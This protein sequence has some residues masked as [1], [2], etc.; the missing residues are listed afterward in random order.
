LSTILRTENLGRVLDNFESDK[1]VSFFLVFSKI[2]LTL[3]DFVF[4][5]ITDLISNLPIGS[6]FL[7]ETVQKSKPKVQCSKS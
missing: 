4:S 7:K 2:L 1:A 5:S 3:F 6:T